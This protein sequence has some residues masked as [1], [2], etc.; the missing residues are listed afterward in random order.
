[1]SLFDDVKINLREWY[2]VTFEKTSEV[3]RVTARGYEKFGI[4]RDIDRQ[5]GELG[6]LVYGAIT[7]GQTDIL[8]GS[9]VAE[10]VQRISALE[11]ELRT[12][13]Q[14]IE[15]IRRASSS[16]AAAGQAAGTTG[17]A[18]VITDPVLVAGRAESAI[19]VEPHLEAV[20]ETPLDPAAG[21]TSG[22]ASP[23]N[24][25]PENES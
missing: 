19:L 11:T 22:V 7:T 6:N 20:T 14:E 10:L 15:E 4:S 12:K 24:D 18:A 8:A 17:A 23:E 1:M 25:T 21:Q 13:E 9:A 5:F 16:G 2:A 3:A